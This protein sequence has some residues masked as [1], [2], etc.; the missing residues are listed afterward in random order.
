MLPVLA[1]SRGDIGPVAV[2][3][4]RESTSLLMGFTEAFREERPLTE[5][6]GIMATEVDIRPGRKTVFQ[7][8]REALWSLSVGRRSVRRSS[9]G[10]PCFSRRAPYLRR[11]AQR[12]D[13]NRT[14]AD[15]IIAG[16]GMGRVFPMPS[17]CIHTVGGAPNRT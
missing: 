8:I 4:R 10:D 2:F 11:S 15:P 17:T 13:H 1:R 7:S 12:M 16:P 3:R 6:P 5:A 14:K 9:G